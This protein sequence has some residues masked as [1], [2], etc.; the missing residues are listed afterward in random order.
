MKPIT[1]D[2]V[3]QTVRSERRQ[4][5]AEILRQNA[6]NEYSTQM[7]ERL[8]QTWAIEQPTPRMENENEEF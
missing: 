4:R 7:A 5:L 3:L 1:P 6:Q 2:N 8:I